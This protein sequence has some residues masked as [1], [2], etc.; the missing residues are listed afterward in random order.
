MLDKLKVLDTRRRE[1]LQPKVIFMHSTTQKV[2]WS[3][4]SF[5]QS[6]SNSIFLLAKERRI[7]A[8]L[9][10]RSLQDGFIFSVQKIPF[11]LF[12]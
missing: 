4:T 10:P 3:C 12:S 8:C 11:T 5:Q 1:I 2:L 9:V 7:D 6:K